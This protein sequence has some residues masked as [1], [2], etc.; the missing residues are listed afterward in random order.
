MSLVLP[1]KT[2]DDIARSD[3][4]KKAILDAVGDLSGVEIFGDMVLLGIYIRPEKTRGGILRPQANVAEDVWQGKVGLVLKWGPD[5]FVDPESGI[6]YDQVADVGEWCV[7][8]VG[9]AWNV[10]IKG[11]A[12]RLVR[13]SNIKMKLKDPEAVL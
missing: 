1:H 6:L 9:D 4:P 8:K 2:I 3:D 12:C 13:D 7:F 5:A 11:L 10:T